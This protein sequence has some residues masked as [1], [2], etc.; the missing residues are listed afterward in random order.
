MTHP[1]F[2]AEFIVII[3]ALLTYSSAC[4]WIVLILISYY[5]VI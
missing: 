5:R 3:E 1:S 2:G 4:N